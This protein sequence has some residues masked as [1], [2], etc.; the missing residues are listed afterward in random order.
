M[1]HQ[2][3]VRLVLRADFFHRVQ[4]LRNQHQHHHVF[5]RR[6]LDG[7]RER[8]HRLLQPVNDGLAL[9]GDALA[10]QRLAEGFGLGLLHFQNL[11]G[12]PA[13]VGRD[14][15]ALG[16][17]DLIHR[18]LHFCVGLDVGDQRLVNGVAVS[19]H[20]IGEAV[21]NGRRDLSLLQESIVQI[22]LGHVP[23]DDV[24]YVRRYLTAGAGQLVERFVHMLGDDV[25]LHRDRNFDEHVVFGLGL[26]IHR[27][28][29]HAQVEP[30]GNLVNPRHLEIQAGGG[31][32]QKLPHTLDD[33][34]FGGVD[35]EE[36]AQKRGNDEQA[37]EAED[38]DG[39][40]LGRVHAILL[41]LPQAGTGNPRTHAAAGTN[42]PK[43]AVRSLIDKLCINMQD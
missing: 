21:A 38:E 19:L 8:L 24:E 29:L 18:R 30:P 16:G 7:M 27:E 25:I 6:A 11:L 2:D 5:G 20:H 9:V 37:E 34:R 15:L 1:R 39:D 23:K 14:L 26:N 4:I 13:G 28:L 12:F 40:N 17:V 42:P 3:R 41:E 10:L 43:V 22:H 31:D 35:L 32:A 36:S 33:H